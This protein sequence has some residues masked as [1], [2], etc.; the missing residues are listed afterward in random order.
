MR[1]RR[2]PAVRQECGRGLPRAARGRAGRTARGGRSGLR[3]LGLLLAAAGC[4]RGG[5]ECPPGLT[6]CLSSCRDL[7]RDPAHC[8]ACERACRVGQT[9]TLGVCRCPEDRLDCGGACVDPRTDEAHCGACG[10]A[11]TGGRLCVEGVC[12]DDCGALTSC[13]GDCADLQTDELHCGACG[14]ACRAGEEC[15]SGVCTAVCVAPYTLCGDACVDL[16]T[17]TSHCGA[18]DLAC[19]VGDYCWDGLCRS[20][21]GSCPYV[22]LWDGQTWR[23][24]TDLS[25]SPLGAGLPFFKPA[26]YGANI[27]ELGDFAPHDGLYRMRL[28]ELVFESSYVDETTLLVVDVP[29]GHD[30]YNE[31]TLASQLEREPGRRFLSVRDPRPPRFAVDDA[32]RDVLAAVSRIDGVPLPVARDGLSRVVLD[33]GPLRHPERARLVL[34][35]WGCYADL[36]DAQRPPYSA[37]TTVETPDGRGGWFERAVTGKSASGPRTWIFDLAGTLPPGTSKLRLTLAHQPSVLDVLDAVLLDDSPPAEVRLT[38][39]PARRVELRRGGAAH[40]RAATLERRLW[41]DDAR[42]PEIP[43]ALL[44]GR[45]TRYGDVRPLLETADD[46]FVLMAHGDELSLEFEAPPERPGT[47]RRAFLRADVWYTLKYHPFG[48]LTDSIDPLPFHGMTTYPYPPEEWP[49]R[50]DLGYARYLQEWNTR[51]VPAPLDP[52]R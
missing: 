39:V 44:A 48:K 40:A 12:S 49:Y 45:Y 6:R 16:Q 32:G 21:W 43:D 5:D 11:C 33:F 23:F 1:R 41:A 24:H 15:R 8:G 47:V 2:Q 13:G 51:V 28:R 34:A 46:R 52:V 35:T 27:Y 20:R 7:T 14:N 36:R 9:C 26:F 19:N 10:V 30:V 3:L 50:R 25:G 4:D 22:F 18:C 42:L 17:D 31:W 29:A 37:A 38:E